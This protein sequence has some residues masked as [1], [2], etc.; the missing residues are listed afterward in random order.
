MKKLVKLFILFFLLF[1]FIKID[2]FAEEQN[3]QSLN[4]FYADFMELL[5]TE[6]IHKD[7][8]EWKEFYTNYQKIN[9]NYTS[10][11]SLYFD[12]Y[13]AVKIAGGKHSQLLRA[14][15]GF[16]NRKADFYEY[17]TIEELDNGIIHITIP[18]TK[19][20]LSAV[21][22]R[23]DITQLE[24]YQRYINTV[25]D[26]IR[27]N[28]DKIKGFIIDLRNNTGG[29]PFPMIRATNFLFNEGKLIEIVNANEENIGYIELQKDSLVDTIENE[30]EFYDKR[31]EK[32]D[33]PVAILTSK[34]T[35]S[36]GEFLCLMIKDA[37]TN[38]SKIFG[39]NTAK[40]TSA[41]RMYHLPIEDN[42]YVNLTVGYPKSITGKIYKEEPIE[43]DV[44]TE[45]PLED[46][47]EWL[48]EM[49]K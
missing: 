30:V 38:S 41:N 40:Y 37:N 16:E 15:A 4:E 17:P 49:I 7:S 27:N 29:F 8:Q 35:G 34:N 42:Y 3:E 11:S 33:V 6:A 21:L 12:L 45:T 39:K 25:L 5:N 24:E 20:Y 2:A 14:D 18:N 23:K 48:N 28:K 47:V 44:E 10:F 19:N 36:A 26:Y 22:N 32:I 43:P 9:K 31:I 46:A 13:D 1:P